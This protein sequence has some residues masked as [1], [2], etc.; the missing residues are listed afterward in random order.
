MAIERTM[1][2]PQNQSA[3]TAMSG[4]WPNIL[5]RERITASFRRNRADE[6]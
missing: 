3:Y 2:H 1:L 6:Y 4:G 5:E